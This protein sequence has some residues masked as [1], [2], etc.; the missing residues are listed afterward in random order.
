MSTAPSPEG[1][2]TLRGG[3]LGGMPTL[4]AGSWV[5]PLQWQ[6]VRGAGT[7]PGHYFLTPSVKWG[8]PCLSGHGAR[9]RDDLTGAHG[10]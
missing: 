5:W 1:M 7:E 2:V 3:I 6:V 10:L 4:P 9:V 8:H